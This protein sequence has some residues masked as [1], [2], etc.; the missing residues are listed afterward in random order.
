MQ[1][2][3][4]KP[5]V[6]LKYTQNLGYVVTGWLE[7]FVTH[8]HNFDCKVFGELELFE[9]YLQNFGDTTLRGLEPL[10]L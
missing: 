7:S 1:P 9:I 4:D 6:F 5:H 8:T 3:E 2:V 10:I